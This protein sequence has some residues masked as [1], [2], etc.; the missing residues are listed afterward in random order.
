MW[1]VDT[2]E[3]VGT[4]LSVC[5]WLMLV[6]WWEHVCVSMWVV[7]V[8]GHMSQSVCGWLMLVGTCLCQHVGG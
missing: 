4:C 2:G 6:G 8:G 5:G 7:D 1:V 3:L